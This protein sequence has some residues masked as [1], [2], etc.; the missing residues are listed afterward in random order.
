MLF[1]SLLESG[2]WGLWESC[3]C[4]SVV[5]SC[6]GFLLCFVF[7]AGGAEG[8]EVGVLVVVGSAGVVDVV[9]F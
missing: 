8:L 6:G 1:W 5:F 7:V 4:L 3:S 2:V 9:D